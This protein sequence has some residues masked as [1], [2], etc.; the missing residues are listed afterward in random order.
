MM[1]SIMVS[2]YLFV[3]SFITEVK[4]IFINVLRIVTKCSKNVPNDKT[5]PVIYYAPR[6]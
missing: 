4:L 3:F 1:T 5:K 6:R 2:L